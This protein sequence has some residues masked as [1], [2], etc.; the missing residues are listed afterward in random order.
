M[1][2]DGVKDGV[3]RYTADG[4]AEGPEDGGGDA[5]YAHG[6]ESK[7]SQRHFLVEGR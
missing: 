7:E 6:Q 5:C 3:E 4:D 1:R 2:F